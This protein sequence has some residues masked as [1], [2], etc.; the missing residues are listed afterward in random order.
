MQA[1]SRRQAWISVFLAVPGVLVCLTFLFGFLQRI[2]TNGLPFHTQLGAGEYYHAVGGAYSDG[3]VTG[4]FFCFFL[5]VGV[6]AISSILGE[7][8]RLRI[9]RERKQERAPVPAPIRFPKRYA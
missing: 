2:F 3:F 8:R 1:M 6:F 5:V 7:R 4:F 9:I